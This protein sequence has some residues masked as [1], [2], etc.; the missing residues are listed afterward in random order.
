MEA[1]LGRVS[2]AFLDLSLAA[3]CWGDVR[4]LCGYGSGWWEGLGGFM[5]RVVGRLTRIVRV[6]CR[7]EDEDSVRG[8]R[9]LY[10][11]SLR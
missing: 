7:R 4:G 6:E 1:S 8:Q 11:L 10:G 3:A 5:R 2:F 9:L